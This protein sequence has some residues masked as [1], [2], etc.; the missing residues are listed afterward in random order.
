MWWSSTTCS[1]PSAENLPDDPRVELVEGSIADD[2]VLGALDDEFDV[3]FHLATYHGNQSSIANPL[4]DHDNNLITT[5]KLFERLKEF[6]RLGR[7][8]TRRPAARS[9]HTRSTSRR[10]RRRRTERCRSTSTARTRSRRS[11]ASSTPST[12]TASTAFRPCVR[13]SRTCTARRGARCGRVARNAGDRLA[14]R[15]ADVRLSRPQ[16]APLILDNGGIASRDFVY[17][18]DIVRGLIA[19][20]E[21]ASGRGLQPRQRHRDEH[22]FPRSADGRAQPNPPRRSRSLPSDPGI[23]P[24][25]GWGAPRRRGKNSG[26]RRR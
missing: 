11:S 23:T 15:H 17:V 4:A 25:C 3:V 2:D 13:G 14:E 16:G 20:A 5:L 21:R 12:T 24:S 18:D 22:S 9:L 26:S 1:P 6:K 10:S 19:C 8:S 7:S